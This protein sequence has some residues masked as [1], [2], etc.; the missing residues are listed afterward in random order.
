MKEKIYT[1]PVNEAFDESDGCPLCTM[2][3][4]LELSRVKYA[5]GPSMMEPD[6]RIQTN[7]LGF[8]SRHFEMMF[9][10]ENKLS[11]ALILQTHI[12]EAGKKLKF[13]ASKSQTVQKK[14]L[15]S[16]NSEKSGAQALSDAIGSTVSTCFICSHIQSNMERYTDTL[17]YM[18][19]NDE[20]FRNK[21]RSAKFFCLDHWKFLSENSEKYLKSERVPEFL[22]DIN[23]IE[24]D[25]IDSLKSDVDRFV[26]KFD[27]RNA[28]MPWENAKDAPKRAINFLSGA[29]CDD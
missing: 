29:K 11:L 9:K 14:K 2:R 19:D 26:L 12:E 4:K 13:Y 1:I 16:K 28:D 18:W 22:G 7:S 5:L 6:I 20:S 24:T 21:F 3:D 8:C 17:F 23:K 27:Y 15:F 10:E 25:Y